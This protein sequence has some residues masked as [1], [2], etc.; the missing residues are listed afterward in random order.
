MCIRD[1]YRAAD[2]PAPRVGYVRLSINDEDWGLY[3]LVETTDDVFLSRWFADSSGSL[4][5]GDYG[6]DLTH[7]G[8]SELE[9]DEGDGDL[10]ALTAIADVLSSEAS[11]ANIAQ[12]DR[13]MDLDRLLLNMGI[14][15]AI[16]HWDGYT[17]ANNYRLYHDPRTD[18]VTLLPWG[19]DQTFISLSLIHI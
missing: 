6:T 14:E 16:L 3:A 5:E 10:T 11:D 9:V 1:S 7:D 8:L 13:L 19:T 15:A 4:F 12:L 17:T 18:R 2:I